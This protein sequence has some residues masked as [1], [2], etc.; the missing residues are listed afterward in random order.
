MNLRQVWATQREI[1]TPAFPLKSNKISSV[2]PEGQPGSP[3]V[4]LQYPSA[5]GEETRVT[6]QEDGELPGG[7]RKSG[8]NSSLL[9]GHI[10]DMD[11]RHPAHALT[12]A[13]GKDWRPF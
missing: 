8:R 11:T 6:R 2:V 10:S 9:T 7:P 3:R 12:I 13:I 4:W 1:L 5:C